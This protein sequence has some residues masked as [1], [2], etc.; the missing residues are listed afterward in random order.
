MEICRKRG[1]DSG[2]ETAAPMRVSDFFYV[3]FGRRVSDSF[4]FSRL[5]DGILL[6]YV[7]LVVLILTWERP[8]VHLLNQSPGKLI[9]CYM[10]I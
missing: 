4:F 7:Q 1:Q 8:P 10:S 6:C 9:D 2:V 5:G 3:L